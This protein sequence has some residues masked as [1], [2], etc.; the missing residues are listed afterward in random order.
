MDPIHWRTKKHLRVHTNTHQVSNNSTSKIELFRYRKNVLI[1]PGLRTWAAALTAA[2]GAFNTPNSSLLNVGI[3]KKMTSSPRIY[4]QFKK[5]EFKK[6]KHK[7]TTCFEER[8]LHESYLNG[9]L[10]KTPSIAWLKYIQN[11]CLISGRSK[12]GRGPRI[13]AYSLELR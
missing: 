3:Y 13:V 9:W 12:G 8:S 7:Q 6:T 4:S 5:I 11:G 10:N 2:F 1:A